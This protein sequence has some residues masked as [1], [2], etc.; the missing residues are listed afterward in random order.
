MSEIVYIRMRQ[1]INGYRHQV[2]Y[3]S[4]IA[5]IS[6]NK[7]LTEKLNRVVIHTVSKQDKN[8]VII[9]VF[10]VIYQLSQTFKDA[11]FQPLGPNQT[12]VMI[13]SKKKKPALLYVVLIWLL[14]FIGAGMAIMN[15]HF[16]VSMEEVHQHLHFLLT[17][18]KVKHPLWLQIP[19]SVGLGVGMILFFNHLFKKRINEEPSPLEIEMHKYQQDLDQYVA[20]HE[21]QINQDYKNHDSTD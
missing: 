4:D 16:D 2:I 1:K 21:N 6:A 3:L 9:D 7:R 8:I 13:P 11:E 19:Y 17:G 20:Y 12:I 10:R 18:D 5:L 15:F 14:L